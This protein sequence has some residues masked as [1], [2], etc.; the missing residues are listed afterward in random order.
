MKKLH[1]EFYARD[2]LAVARGCVGKLIAHRLP[3]GIIIRLRISEAEAYRGEADTACHASRGKTPRSAMLWEK[4]GTIYVYLCYGMHWMLNVIT[5][6]E[7]EPQGVLI[8]ACLEAPGPGRLTKKLRIGKELNGGSF[9]GSELW[10]EDDG[11]R[12]EIVAAPRVGIDYAAPEDRDAPWR[13]IG[14]F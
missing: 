6:R 9:L 13:F 5:G 10:L 11:A 14:K 8:R 4:P 2:S 1:E 3:D 12:P 7:G